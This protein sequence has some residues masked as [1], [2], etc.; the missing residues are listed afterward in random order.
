MRPGIAL[1][2]HAENQQGGTVPGCMGF[3]KRDAGICEN[4][5]SGISEKSV[6]EVRKVGVIHEELEPGDGI[7]GIGIVSVY[8]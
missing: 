4:R 8:K 6:Y 7:S 1:Q 5:V 3:G 2:L